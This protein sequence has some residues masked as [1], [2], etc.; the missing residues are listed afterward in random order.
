M[1]DNKQS[2]AARIRVLLRGPLPVLVLLAVHLGLGL[3]AIARKS[4][5]FDEGAHF[6]GGF[7]YW[8][9]NDYRLQPENGNW[10]QRW[11]AFPL[12][13]SGLKVRLDGRAWQISDVW[14]ICD[15]LFY[16]SGGDAD[17]LVWRGRLM[18]VL[19]EAALGLLVYF[20]SRR[21]FG[22]Y[23][24]LISL[25]LYAFSPS[26]LANGFIATSDLFA[27]LFFLSASGSLWTLLHRVSPF[28]VLLTCFTLAGLLLS[29]YSGVLIAPMGI[30]MVAV[31]LLN[32]QPLR[33][34]L[35]KPREIHG[36][37]PQLGTFA[38][39]VLVEFLGVVFIIWASYGF[40]YAAFAP[41]DQEGTRFMSPWQEVHE[42]LKSDMNNVV[43]FAR[44]Y[45]LLP[46]GYLYGFSTV[47]LYSQMRAGFL[48]GEFGLHGWISFFPC[49]LAWKTSLTL[50]LMLG[51]AGWAY[52][53]YR[54]RTIAVQ[55]SPADPHWPRPYALVPLLVLFGVYWVV[56]LR[57]NLNIGH[58]HILPTY[59]PMFIFAGAAALWFKA[60]ADGRMQR[61]RTSTN[62]VKAK[63]AGIVWPS[64]VA[65]ARVVL[66]GALVATAVE[67]I[68]FWP[69]YL[70]Y[71]NVLSGGPRHAYRR[72]IDSSLD[73]GQ[74]L[75]GLKRWLDD[76]PEDSRDPQRVYL[77]YFGTTRPEY[78]GIGAQRLPFFFPRPWEPH[79]PRPLTGGLYCLS[80]S[81]LEGV[82]TVPL[83]G[84]WNVAYE[85]HYQ[86]LRQSVLQV[87][88][89]AAN[90]AVN[91]AI[92][93]DAMSR[94]FQ[95][96]CHI[97][98]T[99]RFSRLTSYLRQREPDDEVGYSILIYRL[100]DAD[101]AF[102]MDGPPP[103]LLPAP[104]I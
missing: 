18:M 48:D 95:D 28:T 7:S 11:A 56:A 92:L 61:G 97:Y 23:G 21:L 53:V 81:M 5:T 35:R 102:A 41:P 19:P 52:W 96:A 60:P 99:L 12:W 87:Q 8:A 64:A 27:T 45:H 30:V 15:R 31:R 83:A 89:A 101:V 71:F 13:Q 49:C 77:S 16:E 9:A 66:A 32:P 22:A 78:Y 33:F 17:A 70:A 37:L 58:R 88:A 43:Q 74:D 85:K 4:M 2:L 82:Y 38:A 36:R 3:S 63:N 68:W 40:R 29:K 90:P 98:E 79:I 26:M 65:M 62:R 57:S 94:E 69:H 59:P 91:R 44:D 1:A 67:S 75:K 93:N 10:S 51:L 20:W 42:G 104:E 55:Q 100:T 50:F 73:W 47:L 25:I 24:G 6:A 80:A 39:L 54:D 76:H 14:G 72:L 84:R 86:E 46:E 103:E 34:N